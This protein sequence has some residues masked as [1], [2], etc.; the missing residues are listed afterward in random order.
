MFLEDTPQIWN[1]LFLIAVGKVS[2]CRASSS[3]PGA[4][5]PVAF[6]PAFFDG[7]FLFVQEGRLIGE[8]LSNT[9]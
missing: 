3:K 9:S 4:N 1:V 6:G 8:L 2:I 5:D 7:L